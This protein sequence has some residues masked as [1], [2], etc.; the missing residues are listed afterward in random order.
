MMF[1][2]ES[3]SRAIAPTLGYAEKGDEMSSIQC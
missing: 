2:V 1:D 3:V